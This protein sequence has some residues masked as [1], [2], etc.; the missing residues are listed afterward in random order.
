MATNKTDLKKYFETGDKPT[1][2]EYEE[3]IDALRHVDTKLPIT[4]IENLQNSLDSKTD[5]TSFL[6]HINDLSIHGGGTGTGGSA[7][8]G[9]EIKTAYEAETDTN[10]FT[11][12]EKQQVAEGITHKTDTEI[13]VSSSDKTKWNNHL[14]EYSSGEILSSEMGDIYRIYNGSLYKYTGDF[15]N[16]NTFTTNNI[17]TEL[18]ETPTRWSDILSTFPAPE[19]VLTTPKSIV[20]LSTR[21]IQFNGSNL[22]KGTTVRFDS[23]NIS[24]NNYTYISDSSM[25]VNITSTSNTIESVDIYLNNG[26]EVKLTDQLSISLGEVYIPGSVDTIWE[27]E[28]SQ[29]TYS[30][31]GVE[32]ITQN[33]VYSGYFGEVIPSSS[34][35]S[36][37]FRVAENWTQYSWMSISFSENKTDTQVYNNTPNY[38]KNNIE[39]GQRFFS[40]FSAH[41]WEYNDSIEI[42]RI[43]NT[44]ELHINGVFKESTPITVTTDLYMFIYLARV[45]NIYDI[46]L[47]IF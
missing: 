31:G 39:E 18:E 42:K 1:Q 13:H 9:A 16:S 47:T 3:L 12:I 44:Y 38:L 25:L 15:P 34:D 17:K 2:T 5:A 33:G 40:L 24:I 30:I 23:N 43:G 4:D 45:N 46:E 8:S 26:K 14:T 19:F 32:N 27:P 36:V 29:L 21:N 28:N 37:K 6:N 22:K 35:F 10:A 7:M 41:K 20:P 11:D